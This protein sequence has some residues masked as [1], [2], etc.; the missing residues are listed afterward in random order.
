MTTATAR[1]RPPIV[2]LD[3]EADALAEVALHIEESNPTVSRLLLQ[4]IERARILP[5]AKLPDDVVTMGSTVEFIDER[6]G[7]VHR[8]QLVYPREADIAAGR[9]SIL[10]P[11]GAGLIGMRKG[12]SINWPDRSGTERLLTITGVSRQAA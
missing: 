10:T 8:V 1:R 7:Q 5:P 6:D 11:V 9:L 3:S 2:L 4:E 12:Q